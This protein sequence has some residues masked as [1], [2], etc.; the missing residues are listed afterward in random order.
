M[1]RFICA[2]LYVQ[3]KVVLK[4]IDAITNNQSKPYVEYIFAMP[5]W[6]M[7]IFKFNSSSNPYGHSLV[8]YSKPY[9]SSLE[10]NSIVMNVSGKSKS[11]MINFFD[12]D[13]YLFANGVK[14]GNEQGGMEN[15]SFM[16]VRFDV[17]EKLI[18]KMHR[19]YIDLKA[20]HQVK[21]I[22][23]SLL[24][25][26]IT[27]FFRPY[28]HKSLRGNCAFWTSK[29][30]IHTGLIDKIHSWPSY[31]LFR[32]ITKGYYNKRK[33]H[34][35]YYKRTNTEKEPEGSFMAPFYGILNGY[36]KYWNIGH[37]ADIIVEYQTQCPTSGEKLYRITRLKPIIGE[38]EIFYS[39][40]KDKFRD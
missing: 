32:L 3:Q 14:T 30:L 24:F 6:N 1:S 31:M 19:E 10:Q 9:H 28:F 23:F 18:N 21:D 38:L 4:S 26:H 2:Y 25:Y 16:V 5:R 40:L 33:M 27:N 37:I 35:I 17:D 7:K 15:R 34:I 39:K 20:Q 22:E 13:K 29:G 36:K 12:A 8:R 11:P